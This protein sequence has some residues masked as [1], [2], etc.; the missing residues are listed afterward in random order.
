M[1]FQTSGLRGSATISR[2][3]YQAG[4]QRTA[5][6]VAARREANLRVAVSGDYYAVWIA[7]HRSDCHCCHGG[8][9]PGLRW[10]MEGVTG[11]MGQGCMPTR[12]QAT[13]RTPDTPN[14]RSKQDKLRRS[15]WP[16]ISRSLEIHGA[17]YGRVH[18]GNRAP[19]ETTSVDGRGV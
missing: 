3:Q 16:V 10:V 6:T 12:T 18:H 13:P 2:G 8:C 11:T 14:T 9:L 4:G 15:A 1:L 7:K 19:P 5:V 17:H